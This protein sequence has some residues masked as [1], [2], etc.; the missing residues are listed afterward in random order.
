V[1]NLRFEELVEKCRKR[2]KKRIFSEFSTPLQ[3]TRFNNATFKRHKASAV[4]CPQ[5]FGIFHTL[6]HTFVEN[7]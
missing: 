1:E 7:S 2:T 3:K 6:F 5:H 4:G